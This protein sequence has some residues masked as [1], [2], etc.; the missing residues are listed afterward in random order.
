M[1]KHYG[2]VDG[3]HVV[4]DFWLTIDS[5]SGPQHSR[6]PHVKA[7]AGEPDI[8]RNE[9]AINLKMKLPRALFET[10]S[11]VATI[12]VEEPMPAIHIDAE[13]AAAAVKKAI[14]MDV[15]IAVVEPK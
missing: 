4:L 10:P 9:R 2:H 3:T 6:R 15:H 14:G 1:S 5:G 8:R 7:S 11:I 12:N 13:A